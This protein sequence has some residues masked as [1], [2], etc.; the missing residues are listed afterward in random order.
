V[1]FEALE[2][3]NSYIQTMQCGL[4]HGSLCAV[5]HSPMQ[6]LAV[7]HIGGVCRTSVHLEKKKILKKKILFNSYDNAVPGER[8][9]STLKG[10]RFKC[11]CS[12]LSPKLV[13]CFYSLE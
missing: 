1:E 6:F 12:P 10:K 13:M 11:S 2:I 8:V 4:S 3:L 5:M 7:I 9:F